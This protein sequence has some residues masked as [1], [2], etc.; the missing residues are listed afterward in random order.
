M[1][2]ALTAC[3]K[4]PE[5]PVVATCQPAP[6]NAKPMTNDEIIA[7]THKCESAGLKAESLV[8]KETY[9]DRITSIQCTPKAQ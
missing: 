3:G 1:A 8:S 2:V 5:E 4:R 7:E 6:T 9:G